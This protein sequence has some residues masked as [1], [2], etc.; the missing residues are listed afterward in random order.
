MR[1]N[2]FRRFRREGVTLR[3]GTAISA[4]GCPGVP[5]A[6]VSPHTCSGTQN[7]GTQ[8]ADAVGRRAVGR[9]IPSPPTTLPKDPK[10]KTRV[11]LA[12]EGGGARAHAPKVR[13]TRRVTECIIPSGFKQAQPP[14]R[15]R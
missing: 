10:V 7:S 15:V 6:V 11:H 3:F 14:P 4:N 9:P 2:W 8:R 13:A 5:S 1:L 12:V